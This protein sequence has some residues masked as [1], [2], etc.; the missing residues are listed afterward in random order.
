MTVVVR[1]ATLP[2][3]V[4]AQTRRRSYGLSTQ[5]WAGWARDVATSTLLSVVVTALVVLVLIGCARR[6]PRAWPA[7]A[8]TALAAL[9]LLGSFVYPVVVEP[10]FNSFELV[11]GRPAAPR[12]ARGGRP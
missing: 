6:W 8:G 12:G 3:A 4:V 1:L 11:A 7:V 5:G 10:L 2:F 9:V